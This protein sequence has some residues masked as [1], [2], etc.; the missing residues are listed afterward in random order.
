M[1]VD[2]SING[3]EGVLT[4][5]DEQTNTWDGDT[6]A[7][8]CAEAFNEDATD[9]VLKGDII[10]SSPDKFAGTYAFDLTV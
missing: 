9:P 10:I 6:V 3:D 8:A 7:T 4:L 1:D 5:T 2:Y